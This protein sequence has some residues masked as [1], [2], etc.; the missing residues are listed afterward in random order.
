LL[1]FSRIAEK[2]RIDLS[3]EAV[4]ALR[5]EGVDVRLTIAGVGSHELV[6]ELRD[7]V[8]H[9]KLDSVVDFIGFV[10][11]D[12]KNK[13]FVDSDIF[14]LPSENENF[15]VAV[16]E[17]IA[18]QVPVVVSNRVAMHRFV[19]SHRTGIVIERLD[20]KSLVKAIKEVISSYHIYWQG[21]HN[22]RHLLLWGNVFEEWKRIL[23]TTEEAR[24]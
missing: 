18:R 14:L 8:K 3:I 4:R 20:E 6:E 24:E 9:Y 1:S 21:C 13:I 11:G 10:D 15:A 16:A 12:D 23:L 19:E 5:E 17:S 2:K 22:S 7:L